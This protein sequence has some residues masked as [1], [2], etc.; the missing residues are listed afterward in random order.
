MA[1]TLRHNTLCD[2]R[3][4]LVGCAFSHFLG[5]VA[6]GQSRARLLPGG[7]AAVEQPDDGDRQQQE[8]CQRHPQGP[9]A[10]ATR[11]HTGVRPPREHWGTHLRQV[12]L[13]TPNKR[14]PSLGGRHLRGNPHYSAI[15]RYGVG[16]TMLTLQGGVPGPRITNLG[17]TRQPQS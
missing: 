9:F 16:C 12:I 7:A 2:F 5:D 1:F 3:L 13:G 15:P 8:P 6:R 4:H 14:T 11:H 10:Y 17:D